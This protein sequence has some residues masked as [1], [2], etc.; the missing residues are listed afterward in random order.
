MSI[1]S[2]WAGKRLGVAN[3]ELPYISQFNTTVL[4]IDGI[5]PKY[6]QQLVRSTII[7]KEGPTDASADW[8]CGSADSQSSDL[9]TLRE[10][11]AVDTKFARRNLTNE[12]R[13][14]NGSWTTPVYWLESHRANNYN[15][16]Y[17]LNNE[18]DADH[19]ARSGSGRCGCWDPN[20]YDLS[21][22]I[23][24]YFSDPNN[25]FW[26]TVS[27]SGIE[28]ASPGTGK[29]IHPTALAW[30]YLRLRRETENL[31]RGHVVLP[32]SA[33]DADYGVHNGDT[34]Y[35]YFFF[36][37]VN[38]DG[39][40]YGGAYE[41]PISP[42]TMKALHSHWYSWPGAG[43]QTPLQQVLI[44]STI[45]RNGALWYRD[46][47]IEW[48]PGSHNSSSQ[49][50]VDMILSEIGPLWGDFPQWGQNGKNHPNYQWRG[51]WTS[52]RDSLSWWNT[53]L[54]WLTR[55]AP[56]ACNLQGWDV[57]L[58]N[59]WSPAHTIYPCIHEPQSNPFV[60]RNVP[61][62]GATQRYLNVGP[63]VLNSQTANSAPAVWL[64]NPVN[65]PGIQ[66]Y[67]N[68]FT[69]IDDNPTVW[70]GSTWRRAP[71]GACYTVWSYVGPDSIT[72]NLN[73]GWASNTQAGVVGSASIPIPPG[74]HTV[75]FPLIKS[76]GVF[77][78]TQFTITWF[79]GSASLTHG[80][81]V[82]A[83]ILDS[84]WITYTTPQGQSYAGSIS[85]S[86]IYPVI[87]Y[88]PTSSSYN[89]TVQLTRSH[90]GPLAWLG[91]PIVLKGGCSWLSE[92]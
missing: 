79:N 47:L 49:I 61:T 54:C 20:N 19:I 80:R 24:G 40:S 81:I 86:M 75:Y 18:P 33:T 56:S 2:L 41:P 13:N 90:S 27:A 50:P 1:G 88:N 45:I 14:D 7:N 73:T 85:S 84:G 58:P 38:K 68:R 12:W 26:Q 4:N 36:K 35:W 37:A 52:F 28:C 74:W 30:L 21:Q 11:S 5:S 42:A 91:R 67:Q 15:Q 82:L 59:N 72:Q 3:A 87:C 25:Q 83:D 48:F 31:G 57:G 76:D 17:Y 69:T 34:W 32:P 44:D 10:I 62:S 66:G 92:Q 70:Q 43:N 8:G 6:Q 60:A 63:N 78:N 16:I 71:L 53:Y 55:N 9:Q 77:G 46:R 23:S 65:N 22:A 39:A 29:R 64:P 51:I 89:M